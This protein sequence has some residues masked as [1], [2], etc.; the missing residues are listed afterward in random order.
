MAP[1]LTKQ[2]AAAMLATRDWSGRDLRS[3]AAGGRD[4]RALVADRALLRDAGF[5]GCDLRGAS[6]REANLSNAHFQGADLRDANFASADCEGADFAG[7]DLRGT[8]FSGASLFGAS[9]VAPVDSDAQQSGNLGGPAIEARFDA[10][11]TIDPAAIDMLTP[12][13]QAFVLRA[14]AGCGC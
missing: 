1:G 12:I 4:L 14:L 6:F 8:D 3:I 9:F 2:E 5:R 11:T 13:Q 10:A 7:A